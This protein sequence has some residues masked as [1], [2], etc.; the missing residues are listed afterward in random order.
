MQ[1][2]EDLRAHLAA[3]AVTARDRSR[4]TRFRLAVDRV[5]TLS[6]VGVVVTGTVLAGSV[7]VG[8]RVLVSP[9]GLAARVRSLHAQNRASES[10]SAGD[11]CALAL[12]GPGIEKDAIRR[13]DVALD[14]ALHAPVDRI[15]ALLRVS[16]SEPKPVGQWRAV[17][18]HHA[19]AEV[20]ARI[21][22]L[23]GPIEPGAEGEVQLVLDRPIAAA[24]QDRFVVRDPS[25]Q[26]TVGGGRFLDLRPPARKRTHPGTAGAAR[27]ARGS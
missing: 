7:R 4:G 15:D 20:G 24:A 3:A 12:A 18:L 26:R 22:P 11:R 19:A 17:R 10:A 16:A 9:G 8:D 1:G 27:R 2:V 13:G 14:P 25:A 5:F 21:V 6:G 23:E